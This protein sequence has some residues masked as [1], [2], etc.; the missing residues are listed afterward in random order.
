M[1]TNYLLILFGAIL[2]VALVIYAL[3]N[4]SRSKGA[5]NQHNKKDSVIQDSFRGLDEE[6]LSSRRDDINLGESATQ[7]VKHDAQKAAAVRA[8]LQSKAEDAKSTNTTTAKKTTTRTPT[9][10]KPTAR[11]ATAAKA[12]LRKTAANK[13]ATSR[14]AVAKKDP[15]VKKKSPSP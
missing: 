6:L 13:P 4:R 8:A 5:S 3:I 9:T 12:T 2:I 1:E 14:A 11:T 10:K 15:T 7:P